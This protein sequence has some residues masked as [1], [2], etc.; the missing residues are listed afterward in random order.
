MHRLFARWLGVAFLALLI[1]PTTGCLPILTDP[2][3]RYDALEDAQR[4]YSELL[5]WG[6]IEMAAVYVEPE[7]MLEWQAQ[8]QAFSEIRITD[9]DIGNIIYSE[10]KSVATV[11]VTYHGYN[12]RT[13]LEQ[14]VRETQTWTRK[15]GNDWRITP[16]IAQIV[17]TFVPNHRPASIPGKVDATSSQSP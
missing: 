2:L 11:I 6:E 14:P 17:E 13:L 4:R 8:A 10:D 3:G 12:K 7:H 9:F 15:M 1:T 16:E 5:R